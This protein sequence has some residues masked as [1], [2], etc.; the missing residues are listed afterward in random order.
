[1]EKA[2]GK[3]CQL[4]L[5]VAAREERSPQSR[6]RPS[7][8]DGSVKQARAVAEEDPCDDGDFRIVAAMPLST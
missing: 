5:G 3:A 1:M 2:G 8:A 6:K 4:S 7:T